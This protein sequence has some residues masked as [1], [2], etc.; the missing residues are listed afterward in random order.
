MRRWV[1]V[2]AIVLVVALSLGAA[3]GQAQAQDEN[4][5]RIDTLSVRD[6][7]YH[8]AGGGGNA[9]ALIGEINGAVV[10]VDSKLPGW[11]RPMLDAIEQVTDLSVTT[12]IN[13][14]PC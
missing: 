2:G 7:L 12:I 9:L 6:T 5:V 14:R 1:R 8:F 13:T 4:I 11:G 3:S 10:L